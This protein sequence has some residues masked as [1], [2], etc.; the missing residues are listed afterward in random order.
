MTIAGDVDGLPTAS[1]AVAETFLDE[2]EA[3]RRHLVIALTG[4]HAYGFPSVDSDLDLK[5]VHVEPTR[6]LLGLS[7]PAPS[8]TVMEVRQGVELDYTSNELGQV[9]AGLLAGNGSYLERVLGRH[10]L[11][12]STDGARLGELARATLS[13][14]YARH[15]AGFSRGQRRDFEASPAPTAKKL[16]YVLRTA[17]T[18]AWLLSHGEVCTE[19]PVLAPRYGLGGVGEL[20]A[21]KRQQERIALEASSIARWGQELDR[22]EALLA[23][24]TRSSPLPEEPEARAAAELEDWL[25]ERRLAAVP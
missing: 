14:R 8:V 9:A 4:A 10:V 13:R 15:Y 6:R 18:G 12:Q 17:L 24:A 25:V 16:L 11:R 7:P 20:I 1:R 23:E 2:R 22:L 3:D 21:H 19:L 5:G